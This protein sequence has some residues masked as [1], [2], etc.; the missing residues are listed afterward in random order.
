MYNTLT[1]VTATHFL[2]CILKINLLDSIDR[3]PFF[4]KPALDNT[5]CSLT[6]SKKGLR[7]TRESHAMN[8]S[9]RRRRQLLQ[10]LPFGLISML[11]GLV[12]AIVEQGILGNATSYPSTG[13]PYTFNPFFGT[14]L[15]LAAGLL[16]GSVEVLILNKRFRRNSFFV[17]IVAKTLI[18]TIVI[19]IMTLS[20]SAI[21]H[22]YELQ[23]HP[24][25]LRVLRFA[26]NFMFSFAFLSIE[27]YFGMGVAVSLFYL[28]VSD[29]MGQGVLFNFLTGKYH[30]P[31]DEARIFMFLDMKDSTAI[32]EEF[33]HVKYFRML[34]EYYADITPAIIDHGGEIYQYVGDEVVVSWPLAKGRH[35][36]NCLECF[37]AMKE[38]LA[39]Q[40][41][42]YKTRYGVVPTFKAGLHMGQV[43]T[44]EIGVIKKDIIFSGDVLNTTARIQGLCNTHEVDLLTSRRLINALNLGKEFRQ[45]PL[46]EVEIRGRHGKVYLLTVEKLA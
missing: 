6:V 39:L 13:N 15:S 40:K 9:A 17:K 12:Y 8:I 26:I 30:R 44:G 4:T 21:G 16:G 34:R 42:K 36:N 14:S 45:R 41:E 27:A 10:I 37:F 2:E 32:A 5:L 19:G 22:A 35:N 23:T 1:D 29:N 28:E 11:F 24:F 18:Y 20:I 46:G 43:T 38:A 31:I 33:G 3:G 25:D 7:L